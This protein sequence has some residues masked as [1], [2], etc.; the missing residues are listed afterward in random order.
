MKKSRS[1]SFRVPQYAGLLFGALF[2]LAFAAEIS[3]PRAL[4]AGALVV[5]GLIAAWSV[6]VLP[7]D[8]ISVGVKHAIILNPCGATCFLGLAVGA[9]APALAEGGWLPVAAQALVYWTSLVGFIA[10]ISLSVLASIR[11]PVARQGERGWFI[12]ILAIVAE[13]QVAA[14][15]LFGT[16]PLASHW[17]LWLGSNLVIW[18]GA[19]AWVWVRLPS[20][21]KPGNT[22]LTMLLH[23]CGS[24]FFLGVALL[25]SDEAFSDWY[26][27]S[28]QSTLFGVAIFCMVMSI[29]LSVFLRRPRH[30]KVSR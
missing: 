18:S 20:G 15:L 25:T 14:L 27:S 4:I 17:K 12:L 22:R 29:I 2:I 19:M 11:Q 6:F 3:E 30:R 16:G 1:T 13:L 5:A 24:V 23:P 28:A 7:L 10:C 26:Q 21:S 9:S 8:S